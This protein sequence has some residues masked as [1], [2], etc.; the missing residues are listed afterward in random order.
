MQIQIWRQ[1]NDA[2]K[3]V[4]DGLSRAGGRTAGGS[5]SDG[6]WPDIQQ[7]GAPIEVAVGERG[8]GMTT[9][10]VVELD[11]LT[12]REESDD[13]RMPKMLLAM[14]SIANDVFERDGEELKSAF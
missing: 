1:G 5:V 6:A 9:I 2:G 12:L 13:P 11:H 10:V 7:E 4:R 3:P 14:G 8:C